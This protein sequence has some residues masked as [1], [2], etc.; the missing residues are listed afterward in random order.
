M[1]FAYNFDVIFISYDEPN[2]DD[3]WEYLQSIVGHSK[4]VHGVEGI[5]AAHKRAAEIS[6]T[7]HFFVIDGDSKPHEHFFGQ[8]I[9]NLNPNYVYSWSATNIING[10]SYGNGGA[11]LWPKHIMLKLQSHEENGGTDFCWTVP[12]YQMDNL[13]SVT[14]CNTTPYQAFRTGFREGVRMSLEEGKTVKNLK[15]DLWIGNYK[16]LLTW[17]NVGRDVENGEWCMCGAR[18]GCYMTNYTDFDISL[19]S[20]YSWFKDFWGKI[21]NKNNM[22]EQ[23]INLGIDLKR[24][25]SLDDVVELT[26]EQSKFVKMVLHN[27]PRKGLM[28]PKL[29]EKRYLKKMGLWKD[30]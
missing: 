12:Y 3:N 30:E 6:D 26:P 19:I 2:A 13:S 1:V 16:R 29:G 11:K 27:P 14:Y 18:M 25:Y 17:M 23:C 15:E 4:R 8:E 20:D 22:S 5:A 28:I 7:D 21:Q 24:K 10:L 9:K